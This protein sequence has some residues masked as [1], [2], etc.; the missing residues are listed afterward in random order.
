[1]YLDSRKYENVHKKYEQM[2]I[3]G[4]IGKTLPFLFVRN[5]W[6]LKNVF[7][8]KLYGER[9][10]SFEFCTDDDRN[11]VLEIGCPHIACKL[12]VVRPWQLFVEAKLEEMKQY[13]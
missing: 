6:R 10:Y 1:M 7:V 2:V 11:K 3:G 5:A 8:M 12:F 13:Q 4:F 9:M